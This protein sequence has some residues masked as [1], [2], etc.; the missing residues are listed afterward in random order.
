MSNFQEFVAQ[1]VEAYSNFR[2]LANDAQIKGVEPDPN[3]EKKMGGFFIVLEHPLAIRKAAEDFSKK[4]SSLIPAIVYNEDV[5]HTSLGSYFYV[6]G[7]VVNPDDPVHREILDRMSEAVQRALNRF[8]ANLW[9][10]EYYTFLHTLNVAIAGGSPSV[11]GFLDLIEEVVSACKEQ[12]IE[13]KPAWGAHITLSRFKGK[14]PAH[15]LTTFFDLFENA[16]PLGRSVPTA[17]KV[18]Y[19]LWKPN[20]FHPDVMPEDLCGHFTTYKRFEF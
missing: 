13:L 5:V 19:A 9:Y 6:P 8:G 15:N 3:L 12:K 14:V 10:I 20:S 11:P 16:E 2:K 4:I 17:V 1:Q 7:L 18:G